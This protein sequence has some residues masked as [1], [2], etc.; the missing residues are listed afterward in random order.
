MKKELFF[1][2]CSCIPSLVHAELSNA[3]N[4][5]IYSNFQEVVQRSK[6]AVFPTVVY[7]KCLRDNHE[8]GKK[9]SQE[10]S[11]S[12]V[13]ISSKGEILTNW[14]VIEKATEI[15]CLLYSGQSYYATLIGSDQDTDLALLKLQTKESSEQF[16]FSKLGDS[17]K[18]KEG[19]FVMAMGA[20]WGMARS[21]SIGIISCTKRY[22]PEGEYSLWLQTDASICPGNSGGPL[23]NTNGRIIGINTLG[24]FF[25]GDLG[26]A[27]PS[28][29]ISI[30]LPQFRKYGKVNWSW[31]GLQIQALRDFNR[32]I[33]FEA[34]EGIIV[35]ETD[36]DSPARK[37]GLQP[38]DRIIRVDN[39]AVTALTEE[40]LP[41]IRR[42][43]GLLEK[44]KSTEI[45]LVRN[46][47]T[48]TATLIP[49]EKGKVQGEEMECPRWDFT[50]KALNQFENPDLY[51]YRKEG[52]FVFGI[53]YPGNAAN[54]HLQ[55]QDIILKVDGKNI[56]SLDDLK[57]AHE[58]AM[59][60]LQTK[61]RCVFSVLRNGLMQQVVLE[62]S[63][64]YEKE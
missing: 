16:P 18:L 39:Q 36:P 51:Y 29:T 28:E 48:L 25:G 61:K 56:K 55:T 62:Y 52:V 50:V 24:T 31:L 3:P 47:K 60:N 33:Y 6:D 4:N 10:V 9:T 2:I 23:I 17:A 53:K 5:I 30:I 41:I 8:Q 19:D 58:I 44:E 12:G 13:I 57:A 54:S 37:A 22:L 42:K 15:R 14:H 63:R 21:V 40:D 1:F 38:R 11:G 64:D 27:V 46:G 7:I 34:T 35:A 49:T 20:P 32:N 43:L 59:N 26:F 45:E